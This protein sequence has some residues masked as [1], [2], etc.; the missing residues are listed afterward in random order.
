MTKKRDRQIDIK[1]KFNL[2]YGTRTAQTDRDGRMYIEIH[3]TKYYAPPRRPDMPRSK[4]KVPVQYRLNAAG[5]LPRT[6]VVLMKQGD[7]RWTR[8]F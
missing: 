3:R 4:S 8:E 6:V 2:F 5:E 1:D 7:V